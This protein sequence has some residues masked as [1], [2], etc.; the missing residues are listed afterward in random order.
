VRPCH[1]G[2]GRG[3][4]SAEVRIT[5]KRGGVAVAQSA[6][7]RNVETR[8]RSAHDLDEGLRIAR[9]GEWLGHPTGFNNF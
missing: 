2:S 1:L 5:K 8:E 3:A 7:E 4:A 6:C 9:L